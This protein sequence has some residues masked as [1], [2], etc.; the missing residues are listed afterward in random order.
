MTYRKLEEDHA[1]I[2]SSSNELGNYLSSETLLWQM[3]N[4]LPP[5]TSGNL[6][7]AWRR[8]STQQWVEQELIK[9]A[10]TNLIEKRR[11]AWEKKIQLELPMRLNQWKQTIEDY[12]RE[13]GIDASYSSNVEIRTK[14]TLLLS[15]LRFPAESIQT[16]LRSFDQELDQWME[17]GSFV[18]E[19][20]LE[21]AFP[22]E[23]HPYLYLKRKARK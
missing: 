12:A 10:L 14:L 22:L 8:L 21:K 16:S 15:A 17:P 5:L 11:T 20:D 18:W 1:F 4:N 13:Q 7:L 6:L 9:E 19:A 2:L 3:G 23:V